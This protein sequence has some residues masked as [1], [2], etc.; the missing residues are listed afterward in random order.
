MC[1]HLLTFD[2]SPKFKTAACCAGQLC[3]IQGPVWQHVD[4]VEQVVEGLEL[5]QSLA[6]RLISIMCKA[7][8]A[9]MLM[10]QEN[11]HFTFL[12]FLVLFNKKVKK[13]IKKNP[14]YLIQC[15]ANILKK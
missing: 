12:Y 1:H 2:Q 9:C 7:V 11:V 8:Y 6:D 3:L 15:L 14:L 10:H 5:W 4:H 13:V